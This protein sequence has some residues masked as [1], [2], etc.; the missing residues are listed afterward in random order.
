MRLGD[1]QS[2]VNEELD[3]MAERWERAVRFSWDV[4]EAAQA[5][6]AGKAISSG[7]DD[8][9]TRSEEAVDNYFPL[10]PTLRKLDTHLYMCI[11]MYLQKGHCNINC[12]V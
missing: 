10:P 3:G 12:R 6:A 9:L 1:V 4:L 11:Q 2:R 7:L 5:S 8:L